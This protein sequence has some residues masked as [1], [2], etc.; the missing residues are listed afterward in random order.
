M[1][2]RTVVASPSW[3]VYPV[4]TLQL[5]YIFDARSSVL[6]MPF[7]S[8]QVSVYSHFVFVSWLQSRA[9]ARSPWRCHPAVLTARRATRARTALSTRDTCQKLT[10]PR[11][12][13]CAWHA[14]ATTC[15]LEAIRARCGGLACLLVS[16]RALVSSCFSSFFHVS[17]MWA[18]DSCSLAQ[19]T[20]NRYTACTATR[21]LTV[22]PPFLAPRFPRFTAPRAPETRSRTP[23]VTAWRALKIGSRTHLLL[24]T[25]DARC[26][27]LCCK[28]VSDSLLYCMYMRTAA[29]T[30]FTATSARLDTAALQLVP[31]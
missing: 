23:A 17:G 8:K 3:S 19:R 16:Q 4:C 2:T 14:P 25:R 10:F 28:V 5:Q 24:C 7:A 1:A 18:C 26:Q 29:R 22:S 6:E 30:G 21:A 15:L 11:L 27:L 9:A 13:R 12:V 31:R 20:R